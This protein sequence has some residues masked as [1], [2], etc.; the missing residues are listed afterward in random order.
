MALFSMGRHAD[1]GEK[2]LQGFC[3]EC[4][5]HTV[6]LRMGINGKGSEISGRDFVVSSILTI[7]TSFYVIYL[8]NEE[9]IH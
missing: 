6:H 9:N 1:R 4:N 2:L 7:S 5:F 8:M 3:D